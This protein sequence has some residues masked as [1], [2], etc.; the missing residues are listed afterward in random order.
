MAKDN[1]HATD[2]LS[3]RGTATKID[4]VEELGDDTLEAVTG[5]EL[6]LVK[7]SHSGSSTSWYDQSHNITITT[8]SESGAIDPADALCLIA[9][10]VDSSISRD[11]LITLLHAI[12][13]VYVDG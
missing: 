2:E 6:Q 4:G 3:T 10:Y 9:Q 13:G 7:V 11:E 12:D 5:G 8:R 1:K